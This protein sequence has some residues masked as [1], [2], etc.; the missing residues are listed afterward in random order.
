[1]YI[2][3]ISYWEPNRKEEEE[4]TQGAYLLPTS[5]SNCVIKTNSMDYLSSVHFTNQPLH[6]LGI[7]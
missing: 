6:V 1:M 5:I 3:G 4:V 2:R 7:F